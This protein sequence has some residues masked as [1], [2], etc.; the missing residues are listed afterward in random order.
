MSETISLHTRLKPAAEV[1]YQEAHA[2]IPP[3]LV[4]ALK[5]AGVLNWRI[6]RSGQ[7]LFHLIDVEDYAAMRHELRDHPANIPWQTRMA[8]LLEINDDYSGVDTGL[9]LIWE[10]P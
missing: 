4:S 3:E 2:S 9:P 6:W 1:D 10:M 5:G 7:D 8:E